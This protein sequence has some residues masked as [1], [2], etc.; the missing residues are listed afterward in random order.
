MIFIPYAVVAAFIFSFMFE[1]KN[2]PIDTK[3]LLF[4]GWFILTILLCNLFYLFVASFMVSVILSGVVLC[5]I[6]HYLE[7]I[8]DYNDDGKSTENELEEIL[9]SLKGHVEP[10]LIDD[11]RNLSN[12]GINVELALKRMGANKLEYLPKTGALKNMIKLGR[13]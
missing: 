4:I 6:D 3:L 2:K 12:Q 11:L 10:E 7:K 13:K 9:E 1:N 5:V 8:C